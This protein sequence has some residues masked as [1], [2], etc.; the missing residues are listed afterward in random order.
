MR[1]KK[2][3][4]WLL[5]GCFLVGEANSAPFGR[6][7]ARLRSREQQ[8]ANPPAP[9][10]GTPQA[11]AQA[12]SIGGGG[13]TGGGGTPAGGGGAS[14]VGALTDIDNAGTATDGQV[15]TANG[16]DTFTF[17]EVVGGS[18][19][20]YDGTVTDGQVPVYDGESEEYTPTYAG[21]PVF[22]PSNFI[23][24]TPS[25]GGAAR[26]IR[27]GASAMQ[28]TGSITGS[29]TAL[30]VAAGWDGAA[31]HGIAI[32]GAGAD[33][34]LSAPAA[35]SVVN[36]G[37]AGST[38]YDYRFITGS[39]NGGHSAV[40]TITTT[41]T[42][43]ATLD[44]TNYNRVF[45]DSVSGAGWYAVY[46]RVTTDAS[47]ILMAV[48]N[49]TPNALKIQLD[50]GATACV[51]GD[52]G[53]TVVQGTHDGL[54]VGYDNT[55]RV[56]WV[57]P[58]V[59]GTDTF[60]GSG[61]SVTI[62]TGTGAG[63]Q[64]SAATNAVYWDDQGDAVTAKSHKTLTRRNST[65][66]YIGERML[67]SGNMY[68]CIGTQSDGLTAG[69]APSYTTTLGAVTRDGDVFFRRENTLCPTTPPASAV[70][71]LF[72]THLA[73]FSGTSGVTADAVTTTV[74][75]ANIFRDDLDAFQSWWTL[76]RSP[77]SPVGTF[78][79]RRG[80]HQWLTGK[81]IS[82]AGQDTRWGNGTGGGSNQY[83]LFNWYFASGAGTLRRRIHFDSG[84][85]VYWRP[86]DMLGNHNVAAESSMLFR[87]TNSDVEMEHGDFVCAPVGEPAMEH[88]NGQNDSFFW[89]FNSSASSF[90]VRGPKM[91]YMGLY[92]F[93]RLTNGFDEQQPGAEEVWDH[94]NLTYGFSDHDAGWYMAGGR[95]SHCTLDCVGPFG[96]LGLYNDNNTYQ[97]SLWID[98]CVFKRLLK[99]GIR[100]RQGEL[101]F[102]NNQCFDFT[103]FIDDAGVTSGFF[104]GNT[105]TRCAI[106]LGDAVD[107]QFCHNQLIDSPVLLDATS[108]ICN[109]NRSRVTASY[110][111]TA[112]TTMFTLSDA[113][114][115]G[116][117]IGNNLD[118]TLHTPGNSVRDIN[119]SG[120]GHWKIKDNFH[121]VEGV[122]TFRIGVTGSA[123]VEGNNV[124][125]TYAAANAVTPCRSAGNYMFRDNVWAS[126]AANAALLIEAGTNVVIDGDQYA[127]N[128]TVSNIAGPFEMRN[129]KI[130]SSSASTIAKNGARLIN[131]DFGGAPTLSG[132]LLYTKGNTIAGV[133]HSSPAALSAGAN[134][135]TL[136]VTDYVRL[137]PNASNSSLSGMTARASGVEVFTVNVDAGAAT[138][139]Y[140]NNSGVTEADEYLTDTGA[141][142]VD[143]ANKTRAWWYDSTTAKWRNK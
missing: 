73:S 117:Y 20:T 95:I 85:S 123:L 63:T 50:P 7:R 79:I 64:T 1:P 86:A 114:G 132:T 111:P 24:F 3:L 21:A 42:G 110:A 39:P 5:L 76:F 23:S 71:D 44:A 99:N 69:S 126:G 106:D 22:D 105:F 37:T 49:A 58:T 143:S 28:T 55:A 2:A 45:I 87:V 141:D 131:N 30:T 16:D 15:L 60:S 81:I 89:N 115:G 75:S 92:A 74:S 51:A 139:T 142:F 104:F 17:E 112:T 125:T 124:S 140:T 70:F 94:C 9:A 27:S 77:S 103:A 68:L 32:Q 133:A 40:G 35:P 93:P 102:T 83:A 88:F 67:Y 101:R 43:H 34:G 36:M 108:L 134:A 47:H 10:A 31:G 130:A 41:T 62:T 33:H 46:G 135:L 137:D 6:L 98:S 113:A 57:Y 25:G 82:G 59:W 66:Y 118:T 54:L 52:L 96:S 65:A 129:A 100:W 109:Y 18:G 119:I 29:A 84:A 128:V 120:A 38:S 26:R 122:L 127:M 53:K 4:V 136:P 91:R 11:S 138:L 78:H 90:N 14:S 19:L 107:L 80:D 72:R 12:S 116:E 48:I 121:R 8:R 13:I 61:G 97:S 56:L